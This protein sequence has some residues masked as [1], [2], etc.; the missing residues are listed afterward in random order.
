MENKYC[1]YLHINPVKQEIFY[2]GIG[3]KNRPYSKRSRSDFWHNIVK[4]YDYNVIIIENNLN[5][6]E[7]CKKEV[8][9]IKRIGRRDLHEGTLVNLTD[10]GDGIINLSKEK[11]LLRGSLRVN[12]LSGKK[13]GKLTVIQ[14]DINQ[15]RRTMW[16]CRCECGNFKIVRG[17]NLQNIK[18]GTKSCGCVKKGAASNSKNKPVMQ[19]DK[20]NGNIISIF[21]SVSSAA[22]STNIKIN[23]IY[24]YIQNRNLYGGGYKWEVIS[25]DEYLKLNK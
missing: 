17:E 25:M 5:I 12:D 22:K 14:R 1:L 9:W 6:I 10:G 7:A 2:V 19:L 23:T 15:G 8:Y 16:L 11:L 21:N 18:R 4:K 20:T 3:N 24:A 13:F